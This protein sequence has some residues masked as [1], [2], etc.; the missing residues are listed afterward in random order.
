MAEMLSLTEV[1]LAVILATLA[2]IVYSLRIL[3]L[4]ERRI[5]RMDG[6]LQHIVMKVAKE[7]YKIED[8][9]GKKNSRKS[10]SSKSSKKTSKAKSSAKKRKK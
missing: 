2:A 3:V 6:N 4:L 5:S 8:M 10:S 1:I 9:L 7:E